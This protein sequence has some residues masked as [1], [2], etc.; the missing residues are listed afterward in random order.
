MEKSLNNSFMVVLTGSEIGLKRREPI[1]KSVLTLELLQ[2][3]KSD[4][5]YS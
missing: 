2:L 4:S 5:N 3:E 1:I